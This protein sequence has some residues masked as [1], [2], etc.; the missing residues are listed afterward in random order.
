MTTKL[1]VIH[2]KKHAVNKKVD[3]CQLMID[4]YLR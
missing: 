4:V 2:K 3:I 1:A